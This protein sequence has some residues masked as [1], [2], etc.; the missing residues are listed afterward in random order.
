MVVVV[1]G[2]VVRVGGVSAATFFLDR[3]QA[4]PVNKA[5]RVKS[6]NINKSSLG[7]AA[8]TAARS[9]PLITVSNS[10]FQS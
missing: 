2:M 1:E 8:A 10:G 3:K 9:P 4:L 5:E 7:L 6:L